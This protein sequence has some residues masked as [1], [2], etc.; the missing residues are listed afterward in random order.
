MIKSIVINSVSDPV[1][2]CLVERNILVPAYF[3]V[4]F[5]GVSRFL[6]YIY[7]YIYIYVYE[8]THIQPIIYNLLCK[9]CENIINITF[10]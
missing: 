6:K 10:F 9:Y 1:S 8:Y 2:V 5:Q 7:I 3:D 4:P